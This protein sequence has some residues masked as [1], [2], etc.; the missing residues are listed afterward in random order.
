MWSSLQYF[1]SLTNESFPVVLKSEPL[2]ITDQLLLNVF[3]ISRN[4]QFDIS[5]LYIFLR[6]IALSEG[7]KRQ[8]KLAKP[9]HFYSW[10]AFILM[11]EKDTHPCSCLCP[12]RSMVRSMVRSHV[13]HGWAVVWW[14]GEAVGTFF[15]WWWGCMNN[16]NLVGLTEA[17]VSPVKQRIT[18][19]LNS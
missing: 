7:T 9:K 11:S 17:Q 5:Q 15:S 13:A 4:P 16:A 8:K 18:F 3:T 1:L 14:Y 19:W 6:I 2:K 10:N 12:H